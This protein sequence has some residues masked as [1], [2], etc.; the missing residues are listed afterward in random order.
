MSTPAARRPVATITLTATA[1]TVAS[2]VL[3][4]AAV[5]GP[6]AAT[7]AGPADRGQARAAVPPVTM[8]PIGTYESGSFDQSAAE[9]V[10]Y[11]RGTQRSFVVNALDGTVDVLDI[12]DPTAPTLVG[13]L[14]TPGANSVAVRDGLVAVAQQADPATARGT[15]GLFGAA[16]LRQRGSVRV[17][18]LPDMIT[19]TP[20]GSA[21]VV[22]NEGEPEG[23][24]TGQVDPRGSVSVV[25][26]TRGAARAVA[27]TA[28]FVRFDGH[29]KALRRAGIRLYGPGA[30]AS[31]DLEPEFVTVSPNSN[32]AWVTLQENNAL[33]IVDL[34]RARVTDLVALGTADHSVRRSGIDASDE[35]GGVAIDTWPVQGL[36]LPDGIQSFRR[37][38]ETYL[39]TANEGDA[40]EYDCFVEEVQVGDVRLDRG[41][42]PG[43]ETLQAPENL[44]RL[45][46][47]STSPRGRD[48]YTSLRSFGTR[49]IQVRD[50]QG[51]LVWDSGRMFERVTARLAPRIF[52]ANN[53]EDG[54][55][56]RSDNK[57]PEPEGIEI[58][59]VDGQVYA[60]VGLERSSGIVIVDLTRARSPRFAGYADNRR[61]AGD[62]A[63]GTAGD[64]GPEGL[65]FV[66]PAASPDGT[67]LL[68]VGNE[69][70]GTTTVWRVEVGAA[71]R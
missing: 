65:H 38:G 47:T 53:T 11:D 13:T 19:F 24:C 57:G 12:S 60:F 43:A 10:A 15:V 71:R 2:A 8:T 7:S 36:P 28:S 66:P 17:G 35:D 46:M 61:P 41:V 50:A 29:E 32:R 18:V 68:L 51:R 31:Q 54:V 23:Y 25:D 63:A 5:T 33:A 26:L 21:L 58:G 40:R 30:S 9:I 67:P 70:S 64:L 45:T 52:N 48:G 34:R 42:F 4:A 69:V 27:R 39:A 44:G 37:A 22:A 55:D 14:D 16:G 56:D 6:A 49:S 59:R 62:P 20:D 3:A 1:A